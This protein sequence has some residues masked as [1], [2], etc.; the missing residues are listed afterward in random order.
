MGRGGSSPDRDGLLKKAQRDFELARR[1]KDAKELV[2]ASLLYNSA[3]ERVLRA[4]F[5]KKTHRSPPEKAS[6]AYLTKRADLPE[7]MSEELM[8]LQDEMSDVIEEELEIEHAEEDIL[9]GVEERQEYNTV[10]NKGT[11]ARRL[12]SYAYANK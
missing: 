10:L 7:G 3:I 2:A 5:M 8:S 6:I 12:M 4:I 11:I 9:T 1:Y